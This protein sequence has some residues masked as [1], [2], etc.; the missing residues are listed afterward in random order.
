[1]FGMFF[2]YCKTIFWKNSRYPTEWKSWA[3]PSKIQGNNCS[4]RSY[5]SSSSSILGT[6]KN[7]G[8]SIFRND[9]KSIIPYPDRRQKQK[10][11]MS[12]KH[13]VV[14]QINQPTN[15]AMHITSCL[16][17]TPSPTK[18]PHTRCHFRGH[19]TIRRKLI[20]LTRRS[21]CRLCAACP[22]TKELEIIMKQTFL[23]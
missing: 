22:A 2:S 18:I 11:N 19:L 21:G 15:A 20:R 5:G 16:P 12:K 10:K 14:S 8:Q 17:G 4:T 3:Q 9:S 1:M 6:K 13:H 23:P 7:H